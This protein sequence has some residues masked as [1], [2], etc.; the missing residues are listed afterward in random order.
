MQASNLI[1]TAAGKPAPFDCDGVAIPTAREKLWSH[2]AG[3]G[4]PDGHYTINDVISSNFLPVRNESRLTPYGGHMF[5]A[6]CVFCA[7]TLRLRCSCWTATESG[8]TFWPTRPLEKGGVRPDALA[9][10]LNPPEPPFVIG[11]PLYG[12]SHGGEAHWRR[13]PWPGEKI[14]DV[15]IRLQSKHVAMYARV[16]LSRDRYPIQVDDDGDYAVDRALWL[17]LREIAT[18]WMQIGVDAGI[19]PFICKKS[20]GQLTIPYGIGMQGLA[21]LMR[22]KPHLKQHASAVW[23][24][25]FCELIPTLAESE[26][27]GD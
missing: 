15:L 26:D 6:A 9:T 25:L 21:K 18:E 5:C 20:L 11:L 1:W 27:T 19:K 14:D 16:G 13:T 8:I 3:C 22:L 2:C 12:I 10:V 7:R 4:A 23:W 24:P 17:R